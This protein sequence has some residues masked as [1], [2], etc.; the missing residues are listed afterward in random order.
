MANNGKPPKPIQLT[1]L[2]DSPSG[3]GLAVICD[4]GS[5]WCYS[6]RNNYWSRLPPLGEREAQLRYE[7]MHR[8][9]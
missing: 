4:D 8:N 3:K 1:Y 5:V 6:F 2:D 7:A 9:D